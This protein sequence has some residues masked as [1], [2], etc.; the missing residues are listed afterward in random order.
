MRES[1][2]TIRSGDSGGQGC[3]DRKKF[4]VNQIEKQI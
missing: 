3:F 1:A 2:V 4:V